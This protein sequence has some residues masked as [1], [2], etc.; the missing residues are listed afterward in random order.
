MTATGQDTDNKRIIYKYTEIQI[1]MFANINLMYSLQLVN[2][3]TVAFT[4]AGSAVQCGIFSG[5]FAVPK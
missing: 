2:G 4:S 5:V 3:G 1:Y